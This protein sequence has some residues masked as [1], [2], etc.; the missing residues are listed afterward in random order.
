MKNY[1]KRKGKE[2]EIAIA[3]LLSQFFDEDVR[4]Y[5]AQ[6]KW[7]SFQGDIRSKNKDSI[8]NDY[9]LELKKRETWAVLAWYKKAKDDT[10]SFK[11]PIV[12]CSRN[13]EDDYVFFRLQDFLKLLLELDGFRKGI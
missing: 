11:T 9:H 13:H 8:L 4:R 5:G 6:E 3:H 12:V 10:D 7:K 2:Y 1:S